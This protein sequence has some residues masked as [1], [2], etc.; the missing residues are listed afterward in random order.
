MAGS[1]RNPRLCDRNVTPGV[2]VPHPSRRGGSAGARPRSPGPHRAPQP[3]RPGPGGRPRGRPRCAGPLCSCPGRTSRMSSSTYASIAAARAP[4]QRA[5]A[6]PRRPLPH[7]RAPPAGGTG[8]GNGPF[9]PARPALPPAR[10]GGA[11]PL[12]NARPAPL[13]RQRRAGKTQ[14]LGGKTAST[15]SSLLCGSFHLLPRRELAE[16]PAADEA[17][18]CHATLVSVL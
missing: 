15:T 11:A 6:M 3:Q 14:G 8:T 13:R 12:P 10:G 16:T 9:H 1:G 4:P 2:R 18:P 5:A 17:D 7:G